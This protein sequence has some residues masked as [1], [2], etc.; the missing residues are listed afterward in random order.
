MLL[1]LQSGMA[2]TSL[3]WKDLIQ[4]LYQKYKKHIPWADKDLFNIIFHYNP[5]TLI[6][7][8]LHFCMLLISIRAVEE[9]KMNV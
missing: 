2:P 6:L 4:A 5:G 8:V 9:T 3:S 1:V 7:L